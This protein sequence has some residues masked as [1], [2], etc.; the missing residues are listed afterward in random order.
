MPAPA[1]TI[2][3]QAGARLMERIQEAGRYLELTPGD[4]IEQAIESE[5]ARIEA[6]R[7]REHS[8]LERL[9]HTV[10]GS[11]GQSV[12]V[13]HEAETPEM[14]TCQL[15]LRAIPHAERVEGPLLCPECHALAKGKPARGGA[16]E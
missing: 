4:F 11:S 6:A 2:K 3:V 9:Q 12:S 10:L 14:T 5:L 15:C 8:T 7:Q 13:H 16:A 1:M